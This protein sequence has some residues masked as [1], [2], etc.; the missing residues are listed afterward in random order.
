MKLGINLPSSAPARA[1]GAAYDFGR[2]VD[3]WGRELVPAWK[4]RGGQHLLDELAAM[5][6]AGVRALRWFVLGGGATLGRPRFVDGPNRFGPADGPE[7]RALRASDRAAWYAAGQ[8][9]WEVPDAAS[10]ATV[11]A[12]LARMLRLVQRF[13]EARPERRL[14]PIRVLPSWFDFRFFLGPGALRLEWDTPSADDRAN[15]DLGDPADVE[16]WCAQRALATSQTVPGGR[17]DALLDD[18]VR[19]ALY[20]RV[21]VP[22][23]DAVARDEGLRAQVLCWEVANEPDALLADVAGPPSEAPR[24]TRALYRFVSEVVAL[25]RGLPVRVG[26]ETLRARVGRPLRTTVGWLRWDGGAGLARS[27]VD[28]RWLRDHPRDAGGPTHVEDVLQFHAY[29]SMHADPEPVVYVPP[30]TSRDETFPEGLCKALGAPPHNLLAGATYGGWCAWPSAQEVREFAVAA[31]GDGL[32][33]MTGLAPD[34]PVR[35]DTDAHLPC[36][37]GEMHLLPA[38]GDPREARPPERWVKH[39]AVPWAAL[40][41]AQPFAVRPVRWDAF[42]RRFVQRDARGLGELAARAWPWAYESAMDGLTGRLLLLHTL[43]YSWALPWAWN[44]GSV[45]RPLEYATTPGDADARARESPLDF[46][47]RLRLDDQLRAFA[48]TLGGG[49]G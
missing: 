12:D 32:H 41:T 25:H 29:M 34:V 13:N 18:G 23:L 14:D 4:Q 26:A 17:M 7:A 35:V 48:D 39:F 27:L 31:L 15:Y 10:C 9:A 22:A 3:P 24:L 19:A 11:A 33:G 2:A 40:P 45:E 37:V 44:L 8:W 21:L 46:W 20:R 43:G 5:Y 28:R 30:W 42:A 1:M 47:R 38:S 49:H 36:V 16:L 6:G